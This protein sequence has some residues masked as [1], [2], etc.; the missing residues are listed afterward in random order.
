MSMLANPLRDNGRANDGHYDL[1]SCKPIYTTAIRTYLALLKTKILSSKLTAKH[2]R[3][4]NPTVAATALEKNEPIIYAIIFPE[5]GRRSKTYIGETVEPWRRW[6]EHIREC[7]KY[8]R[9]ERKHGT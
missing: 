8:V 2:N 1:K 4:I 3:W 7:G 5:G 6:C 9:G